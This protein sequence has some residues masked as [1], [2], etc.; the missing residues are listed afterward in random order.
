MAL[1]HEHISQDDQFDCVAVNSSRV[2]CDH[3]PN[4]KNSDRD[5]IPFLQAV[6]ISIMVVDM[7]HL[8]DAQSEI[9]TIHLI[10]L[11]SPEVKFSG[12]LPISAKH[13]VWA[14]VILPWNFWH[15]HEPCILGHDNDFGKATS[16]TFPTWLWVSSP[17]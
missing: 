10:G 11:E 17:G 13:P 7:T 4:P 14:M 8:A 3:Q 2:G 6:G 9:T 15:Q 16:L 5:A 1:G 12:F